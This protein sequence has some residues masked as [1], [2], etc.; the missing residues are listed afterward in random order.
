ME[1]TRSDR[2]V[3]LLTDIENVMLRINVLETIKVSKR[4]QKMKLKGHLHKQLEI[5]VEKSE[6]HNAEWGHR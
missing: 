5:T 3:V 4:K 1:Y 6:T 2:Y